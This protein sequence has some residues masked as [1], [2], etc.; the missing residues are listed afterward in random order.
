MMPTLLPPMLPYV[1]VAVASFVL[2][3][4]MG[5]FLRRRKPP[6]ALLVALIAPGAVAGLGFLVWVFYTLA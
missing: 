5:S 3:V 6:A 2:G 4:V 1:V